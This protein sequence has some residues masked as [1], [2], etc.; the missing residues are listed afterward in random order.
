MISALKV[1][2]VVPYFFLNFGLF[3]LLRL[4]KRQNS[5]Q[6]INI[7]TEHQWI[8][9]CSILLDKVEDLD[10]QQ[11]FRPLP[12]RNQQLPYHRFKADRVVDHSSTA[13]TTT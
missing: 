4:R 10:G 11:V 8:Q 12:P 9:V 13:S 7:H 5:R 1:K 2:H 6:K 3:L